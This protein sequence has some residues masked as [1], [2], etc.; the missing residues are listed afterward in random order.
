M[1]NTKIKL[2]L[3]FLRFLRC[4]KPR[5]LKAT[6]C[7]PDWMNSLLPVTYSLSVAVVKEDKYVARWR[8]F[9]LAAISRHVS[10]TVQASTKV[11][12]KC[13]YC[14]LSK[15]GISTDLEWPITRVSLS[16]YFNYLSKADVSILK[17]CI[18]LP[19]DNNRKPVTK[20]GARITYKLKKRQKRYSESTS[21]Q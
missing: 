10:S 19:Y 9:E 8:S 7:S 2:T 21:L 17:K 3:G 1:T 5:F 16:R 14:G 4:W 20:Q 18:K 6:S 13:E 15:G 11:S 12:M